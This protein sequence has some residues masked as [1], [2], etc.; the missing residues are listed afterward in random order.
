MSSALERLARLTTGKATAWAVLVVTL[1]LTGAVMVVGSSAGS[2]RSAPDPLPADAESA[3]VAQLQQDFPGGHVLPAVAVL[4]RAGGL[5]AEDLAWAREASQRWTELTGGEVS[6]PIPAEDGKAAIIVIDI[7]A[8][9]SGLNLSDLVQEVRAVAGQERPTGL[10]VQ[11]T[12]GAAFAADISSAFAGADVRLLF[13]TALVVAIALIL[14]YRSPVLWLVPLIVVAVA[15][16][17]A[18]VVAQILAD[19]MGTSLD[20]STSGITSVLVFGAGTNYALLLVSRYREELRRYAQPRDALAAAVRGSDRAIVTSNLTVVLALLVLVFSVAPNSRSL[21]VSA[22]AGL[23]VALLF[24][25]FALP[26]ALSLFGRG[27]F[28]PFVPRLEDRS[29]T[30]D[31]AWFRI[32]R[33]VVSRPI[34]VLAVA[35]V[36][37]GLLASGLIGVKFGLSQTDQFRVKAE[38]VYG[39]ATLSEHFPPGAADPVTIIVRTEQAEAVL[40]R[41]NRTEGVVSARP[42]GRSGDLTKITATLQDPP[43]TPESIETI[44]TLRSELRELNGLVG[45][46]VAQDLDSRTG[47]ER[48]LRIVVPLIL[49]VVLLVLIAALHSIVAPLVLIVINVISTLAA[50]GL[51][52]WIGRHVFGFPALDVSTPIY[53]FLFLVALGIDYTVFLVLRAREETAK[54]GTAEAMVLAVGLTGGVITSAGIVLAAVFAVLGVLPLITLT[55]VGLIVGLGILLDTFVIRTIV[56]PAAFAIAGDAIWW[57][58]L[59]GSRNPGSSD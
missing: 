22:A 54:H 50:L 25:L 6:E 5:T 43:A 31:G 26:A 12:G 27:L 28:W 9:V 39:L 13:V 7:A 4:E 34:T 53:A 56:V 40:A 33:A 15:D 59:R 10:T 16:R 1:V 19:Q 18:S 30:P 32:A 44:K 20:G 14:T 37:L 17:T 49:L 38:S 24:A 46:S 48:D 57:P 47:A 35:V 36:V 21:G 8:E 58:A 3:R 2:G 29:D 52:T 51:G 11:V 23:V 41:T 42:T 45:G 55:Q